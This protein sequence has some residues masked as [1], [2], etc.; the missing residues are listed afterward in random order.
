M[1]IFKNKDTER[2]FIKWIKN[3][4]ESEHPNDRERFY[5]FVYTY[6]KNKESINKQEF[7][8]IVI[9]NKN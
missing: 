7:A 6:I 8:E 5:D 1:Y 3:H 9:D 2:E 4:P